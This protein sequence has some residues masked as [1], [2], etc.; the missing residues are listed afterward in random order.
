MWTSP[1]SFAVA[2][3][4]AWNDTVSLLVTSSLI[5]IQVAV[6]SKRVKWRQF[7]RPRAGI[8]MPNSINNYLTVAIF[9]S[10]KGAA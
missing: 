7:K 3:R 10:A 2:F 6:P 4:V 1:S 8:A 9:E 5:G